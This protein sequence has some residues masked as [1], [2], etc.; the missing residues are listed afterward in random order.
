MWRANGTMIEQVARA[1]IAARASSSSIVQLSSCDED[2]CGQRAALAAAAHMC[3]KPG[4]RTVASRAEATEPV[5]ICANFASAVQ[6]F[7]CRK[8]T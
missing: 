5:S 1:D 4:S 8:D 2:G 7:L 3:T 6:V